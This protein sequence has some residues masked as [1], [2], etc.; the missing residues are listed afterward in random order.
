MRERTNSEI[1]EEIGG[2]LLKLS[3]LPFS[4]QPSNLGFFLSSNG[5]KEQSTF[6]FVVVS[7]TQF[8]VKKKGERLTL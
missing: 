1:Q 7:C 3:S 6:H 4:C 8:I 5:T 2:G